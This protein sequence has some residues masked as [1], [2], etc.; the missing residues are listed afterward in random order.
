MKK[1]LA[2]LFLLLAGLWLGGCANVARISTSGLEADLVR[3]NRAANGEIHVTWRVRNPNIVSYV[4]TK[5]NLR[6]SIDGAPVGLITEP[7]RLG[8]PT[9]NQVEQTSVLVP[10]GAAAVDIINRAIEKGSASY[11]F[12]A[13][14]W[15]LVVDDKS[16]KFT[17]TGSGTIPTGEK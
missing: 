7:T 2:P 3:L 10:N 8:V 5:S 16:E 6:V 17:L 11:S 13:T 1:L 12:E 14:V 9:M 15:M 4:L